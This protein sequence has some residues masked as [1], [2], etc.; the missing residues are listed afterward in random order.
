MLGE[1]FLS[2][3]YYRKRDWVAL[4]RDHGI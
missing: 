2:P 3:T 1:D 4:L